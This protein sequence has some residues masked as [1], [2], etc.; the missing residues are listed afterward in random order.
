M[1]MVGFFAVI[2]NVEEEPFLS[3]GIGPF[4]GLGGG[5]GGGGVVV[6]RIA[7]FSARKVA[8]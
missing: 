6:R 7:K 2:G 1:Q 8:I 3:R 4:F 5:G